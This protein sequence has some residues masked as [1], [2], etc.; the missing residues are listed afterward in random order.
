[1]RAFRT[2]A[3]LALLAL[4]LG[5][6]AGPARSAG[7]AAPQDL[8]AFLLRADEPRATSFSRTPAFAWSP[9]PGATS[10]EIQLS[11][12]SA[13]RDNGIIYADKKLTTPVAAPTVTLPWITGSPHSLYAR[14]RAVT[15]TTTSPW[16]AS[17]GFD[18]VSPLPS[19]PGLLRW[20]P[21]EGATGYEVWLIDAGKHEF[22]TSNVLDEREFYTL[23]QASLWSGSV[24]WRIRALRSDVYNQRNNKIPVSQVGP[25]SPV[26]SS[27]NAPPQGGPIKLL[28][29]VADV[30]SDGSKSSPAQRL[31]PAFLFTGNQALD[32]TAA[33]LYRV[34]V[35]TD[36]QCLNPVLVGSPTGAPAFAPRPY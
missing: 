17:F 30:F 27:T 16:S 14:V 8:H 19:Y 26:Y 21:V 5:A 6:A 1:M 23:H 12:S 24:R 2:A 15:Q 11:T 13:F 20:T 35:F 36:K 31:M 28:G 18:V 10:Y 34:Y 29:T 7:L 33:E 32:G 4:A 25:W 9:V 3:G 22:V